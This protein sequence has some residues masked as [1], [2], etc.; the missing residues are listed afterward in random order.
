MLVMMRESCV[1][2]PILFLI[3]QPLSIHVTWV[4]SESDGWHL[5]WLLCSPSPTNH[6][7]SR[8][9]VPYS[10]CVLWASSASFQCL[11]IWPSWYFITWVLSLRTSFSFIMSFL[12][13]SSY[14]LS[15]KFGLSNFSS[16][17]LVVNIITSFL[18]LKQ[19]NLLTDH[20]SFW[21]IWMATF[22]KSCVIC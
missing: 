21:S 11:A 16:I 18:V 8:T 4:I 2:G 22:I 1:S 6:L 15:P 19:V 13:V 12:N 9:G 14:L 3:S 7:S 17:P 10:S 20:F 5:I